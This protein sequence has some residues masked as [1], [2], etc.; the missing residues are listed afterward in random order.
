MH[1]DVKP[2]NILLEPPLDRVKLTD[3]GLARAAEDVK[4]TRTGF[5]T[6]TPLYLAPEVLEGKAPT[7]ASDVY[8]LGATLF[9]ALTGH[10][11]EEPPD[12]ED[13]A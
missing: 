7:S 4:L 11:A 2:G 1:R 3:F 5:V 6:G 10:A 8:S 9:C 13:A 12:L